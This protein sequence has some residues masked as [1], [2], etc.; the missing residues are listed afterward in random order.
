MGGG[1]IVGGCVLA[2]LLLFRYISPL[3]MFRFPIIVMGILTYLY[4]KKKDNIQLFGIYVLFAS[5][6]FFI[7]RNVLMLSVVVPIVLKGLNDMNL[8]I[9]SRFL[10][11][12]G[13]MSFELYLAH[14]IPMN[15]LYGKNII[16]AAFIMVSGTV[17]LAYFY[18]TINSLIHHIK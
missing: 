10:S 1:I 5:F 11:Y 14:I 8:Q 12:V 3:Y 6:S 9:N 17:V 7:E 13:A 15:F 4:L 16:I 18:K 2:S